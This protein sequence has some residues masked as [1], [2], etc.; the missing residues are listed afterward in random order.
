MQAS[1]FFISRF[2]LTLHT[3]LVSAIMKVRLLQLTCFPV[4][5]NSFFKVLGNA[6]TQYFIGEYATKF[7]NHL[8][9]ADGKVDR[10]ELNLY[11]KAISVVQSSGTGKSRMLTEVRP[12]FCW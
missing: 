2:I 6:Y 7:I 1:F 5:I 12:C 9:Q 11:A 8:E 10:N 3:L 4:F